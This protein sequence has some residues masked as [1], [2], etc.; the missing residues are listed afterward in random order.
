MIQNAEDNQ[1]KKAA[2][3]KKQPFLR[4]TVH[5]DR[6]LIDSNEDGFEEVDVRAICSTGKITKNGAQAY[7]GENGIGFKSVFKV[8]SKVHIQSGAFS[9]LFKHSQRDDG[10]G[11]VTPIFEEHHELPEGVRTRMTL[12]LT[13]P[14]DVESLTNEFKDLPDSSLMFLSEMEKIAIAIVK[15]VEDTSTTV[16]SYRYA[17]HL[18]RGELTKHST[19]NGSSDKVEIYYN[20]ITKR[21]SANL[22]TDNSR[23]GRHEADVVLA[24][25]LDKDSAPLDSQQN[26]SAFL[27]I[28]QVGYNV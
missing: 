1:Y 11:I 12:T 9:F 18:S 23:P 28:R 2:A 17:N 16:Y 4:F 5:P 19:A 13:N 7:I 14:S 8:A 3:E 27:P 21:K 15:G 22:P 6:I 24:F 10:L 26:V 20:H 25:P